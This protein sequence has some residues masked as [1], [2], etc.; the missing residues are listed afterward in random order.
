MAHKPQPIAQSFIIC[1]DI[2]Q[3]RNTGTNMLVAP[4]NRLALGA[5][6]VALRVCL[7]IQLTG[8]QGTYRI[9]IQVQDSDGAVV[10]EVP[11]PEP[12]ALADPVAYYQAYWRDLGL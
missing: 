11:G 10:C 5:F 4:F 12:A 9:A 6:P 7:F 3:D 8:G 2:F 1:R